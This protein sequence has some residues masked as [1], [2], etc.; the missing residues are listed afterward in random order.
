MDI[1][2]V[3]VNLNTK[4]LL[5]DALAALPDASRGLSSETI[6]VDNG[7]T[8]GSAALVRER[9]AHAL[10][11]VNEHNA[12]FAAANNQAMQRA[13]GEFVLLLN[14]DTRAA[15]DSI[16]TLARFLKA[17]P[18]AGI[19]GPRLLNA[20]GTFQGSAAAF[21][22]PAGEALLLLGDVARRLRGPLFPYHS[23]PDDRSPRRVDW[24]SGACLLIRRAVIDQIGGLDTGY[25]MYTE[26]TD[27]CYRAR[28][29]GWETWWLPEPGVYHLNG[30][31]AQQTFARKR[32]QIYGSKTRF[33]RKHYG[34]VAAG[35]FASAV[36][37]TSL[38]KT[39]CW[40]GLALFGK[41]DR[42]ER[43]RLNVRSYL[44]VLSHSLVRSEA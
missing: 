7:S 30:A 9:F 25:F 8:D 14:S 29:A 19:V 23:L 31:T 21:P 6:V 41:S 11:I 44:E 17:Q 22:T 13:Q 26:E 2:I 24:I 4:Q 36:W 28:Q 38:I 12:G 42:R 43:A 39:V 18:R 5:R 1:S 20:D 33:F 32:R 35:M 37:I 40:G 3:V 10:L 34:R 27:W 15:P 16:A